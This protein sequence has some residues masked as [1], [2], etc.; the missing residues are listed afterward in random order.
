MEK[1]NYSWYTSGQQ[2]A[3][4]I[5][6]RTSNKLLDNGAEGT[7]GLPC[8]NGI[9]QFDGGKQAC[10]IFKECHQPSC[11]GSRVCM[12]ARSSI[13]RKKQGCIQPPTVGSEHRNYWGER[14]SRQLTNSSIHH[15]IAVDVWEAIALGTHLP[16]CWCWVTKNRMWAVSQGWEWHCQK[17][18]KNTSPI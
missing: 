2:K 12:R 3:T 15:C 14:G 11:T 10:F 16:R 13:C 7:S 1:Y 8:C 6:M 5:Q 4:V 9:F 18:T 17:S